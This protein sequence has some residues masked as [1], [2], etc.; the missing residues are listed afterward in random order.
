MATRTASVILEAVT[1]LL[2]V[3]WGRSSGPDDMADYTQYFILQLF[4]VSK[5]SGPLSPQ[6]NNKAVWWIIPK[7]VMMLNQI[8]Y[9]TS[10][11]LI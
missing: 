11:I 7:K 2:C 6:F 3:E 4:P 8:K 5:I 9:L 10:A 1:E